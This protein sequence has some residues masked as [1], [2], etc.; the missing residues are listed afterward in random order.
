MKEFQY[1]PI[2]A[3]VILNQRDPDNHDVILTNRQ[4]AIFPLTVYGGHEPMRN[5]A[6]TAVSVVG[7]AY[8][9]P[10]EFMSQHSGRG[11][12][13]TP[14][15]EEIIEGAE[16]LGPDILTAAEGLQETEAFEE[17]EDPEAVERFYR[18]RREPE[19]GD[20]GG[21]PS[22]LVLI[23]PEAQKA[24]NEIPKN[25]QTAMYDKMQQLKGYPEIS[26]IKRMWGKAYG[27]ERLKFWDWRMEF[28]VDEKAKTITVTKIGHRDTLYD[29]YH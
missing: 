18:E 11:I 20:A 24:L 23:M 3:R 15:L 7:E 2:R 9:D 1:G 13:A 5:S 22:Y 17:A 27:K 14:S 21:K 26:G 6:R 8:E 19:L 16:L 25:I 4:G 28:V 10:D 12:S 29:E